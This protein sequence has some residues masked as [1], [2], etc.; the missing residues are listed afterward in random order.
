[1]QTVEVQIPSAAVSDQALQ[2]L[3][4]QSTGPYASRNDFARSSKAAPIRAPAS[5]PL[6]APET[7][8]LAAVSSSERK[9]FAAW[10]TAS[11]C[12]G[13]RSP[14][15]AAICSRSSRIALRL[16]VTLSMLALVIVSPARSSTRFSMSARASHTLFCAFSSSDS[17]HATGSAAN[18]AARM[19]IVLRRIAGHPLL[20]RLERGGLEYARFAG[21]HPCEQP[22]CP[23]HPVE[24]GD[25]RRAHPSVVVADAEIEAELGVGPQRPGLD[26]VQ[27]LDQIQG[28]QATAGVERPAQLGHQHVG[29]IVALDFARDSEADS[30]SG[31]LR[32]S[33][34]HGPTDA[35]HRTD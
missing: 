17:P 13:A 27:V 22:G 12:S 16:L 3:Y 35:R 7:T 25:D 14:R 9:R 30:A 4:P 5:S 23:G 24:V 19:T 8:S 2:S 15:S 10:S 33:L 21:D 29:V 26:L 18:R 1:M 32:D 11:C 20:R 6:A 31:H 28:P 34:D